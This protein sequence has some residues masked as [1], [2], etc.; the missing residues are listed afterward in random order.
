MRHLLFVSLLGSCTGDS[1]TDDSAGPSL[2]VTVTI[3]SPKDGT[4]F[5]WDEDVTFDVV[6]KQG[7][8]EVT[9]R[10]VVWTAGGKTLKGDEAEAAAST[11]GEGEVE[12]GVQL[13]VGDEKV[14]A[15]PITITVEAEPVDTDTGGDTGVEP[16]AIRYEGTMAT[17]V[18]Y[19]GD[20]GSYDSDC[21]GTVSVDIL[22]GTMTGTGWCLLDGQYDMYFVI[23]GTQGGGGISGA[24][25]AESDGNEF[26][27][28]F[29][30]TGKKGETL[31]ASYDKTFN[32]SG[33]TV[34]IAGTWTADPI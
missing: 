23:E 9:F 6:V 25:I 2:T 3:A 29:D 24:L 8:E 34:R 12:V 4:T 11:F 10:S 19:D 31:D 33:E 26:R 22:D 16:G 21:P 17:H 28:P 5:A 14:E 15:A 7:K 20:F 27:T 18:W 13:F 1:G 30:G 32:D